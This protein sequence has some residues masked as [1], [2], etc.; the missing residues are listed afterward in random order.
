MAMLNDI[1]SMKTT[2]DHDNLEELK[3]ISR[4]T[5]MLQMYVNLLYRRIYGKTVE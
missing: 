5:A 3:K 4:D 2:I 1:E